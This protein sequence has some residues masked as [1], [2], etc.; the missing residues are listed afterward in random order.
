LS[1]RSQACLQFRLI[2]FE[3]LHLLAVCGVLAYGAAASGG[4]LLGLGLAAAHKVVAL[5]VGITDCVPLLYGDHRVGMPGGPQRRMDVEPGRLQVRS[6]AATVPG[7]VGLGTGV[8]SIR[9]V[10]VLCPSWLAA[11]SA[12]EWPGLAAGPLACWVVSGV[13]TTTTPL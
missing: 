12:E 11:W 2:S 7:R 6:S 13:A 1:P 8:P 3:V 9:D 4:V 10:G 5:R